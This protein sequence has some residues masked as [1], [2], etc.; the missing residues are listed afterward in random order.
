MGGL[1]TQTFLQFFEH[2]STFTLL[3]SLSGLFFLVCSPS[4]PQMLLSLQTLEN[5]ICP[6]FAHLVSGAFLGN[7]HH[8][9]NFVFMGF[10]P[11]CWLH[12]FENLL[13]GRFWKK[14]CLAPV[15]FEF[16]SLSLT[17]PHQGLLFLLS[18]IPRVFFTLPLLVGLWVHYLL[19][20]LLLASA[21]SDVKK[22]HNSLY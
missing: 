2:P 10:Y 19:Q 1:A 9:C 20:Y 21:G 13:P 14:E 8:N 11:K 4:S 15:H 22:T 12:L 16:T 5:Y 6:F 18:A 17:L 3:F 7:T